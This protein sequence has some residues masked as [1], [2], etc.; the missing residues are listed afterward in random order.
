ML[1][2]QHIQSYLHVKRALW[3]RYKG[4]IVPNSNKQAEAQYHI[5]ASLATE[6][7][8]EHSTLMALCNVTKDQLE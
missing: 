1:E 7:K 5:A 6:H 4:D 2:L 8:P 3:I